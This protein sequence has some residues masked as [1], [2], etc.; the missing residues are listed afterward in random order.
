MV[1]LLRLFKKKKHSI[2]SYKHEIYL[3]S[4]LPIIYLV[5]NSSQNVLKKDVT[6]FEDILH[7]QFHQNT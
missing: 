6:P 5:L 4:G 2:F 7:T 3:Y 1:G